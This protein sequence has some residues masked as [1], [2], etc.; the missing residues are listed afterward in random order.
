MQPAEGTARAL[1]DPVLTPNRP[2]GTPSHQQSGLPADQQGHGLTTELDGSGMESA[3][4]LAATDRSLSHSP[5][6]PI[7]H[8]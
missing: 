1:M 5:M 3:H 8:E 4:P 2:A 7:R 6:N